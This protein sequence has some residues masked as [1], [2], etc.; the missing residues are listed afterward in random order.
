[1][2]V[3][4]ICRQAYFAFSETFLKKFPFQLAYVPARPSRACERGNIKPA[5][6]Y[7]KG[8]RLW[9]LTATNGRNAAPSKKKKKKC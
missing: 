1:M 5:P 8:V 6:G 3:C 2:L 7:G 9:D 4:A